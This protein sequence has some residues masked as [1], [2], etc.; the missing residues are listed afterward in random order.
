MVVR[1]HDPRAAED[2]L[3]RLPPLPIRVLVPA[4]DDIV[5]A[6]RLKSAHKL[7]YA[8]A[9]AVA[10]AVK[11]NATIVTGDPEIRHVADL[12]TVEWIGRV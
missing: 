10:L 6:A 11:Q 9:F 5:A 7:S 3:N 8:D 1:K 12:V 2:F 4:E